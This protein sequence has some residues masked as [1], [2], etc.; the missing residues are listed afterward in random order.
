M[1][2]KVGIALGGG[3]VRGLAHIGGV[4]SFKKTSIT[5]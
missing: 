2:A 4:K 1:V 3:A 5:H